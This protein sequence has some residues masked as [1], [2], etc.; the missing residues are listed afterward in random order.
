MRAIRWSP[1]RATGPARFSDALA[2]EAIERG[3]ASG[4][5]CAVIEEPAGAEVYPR[6]EACEVALADPL[7]PPLTTARID[8]GQEGGIVLGGSA[9]VDRCGV[10]GGLYGGASGAAHAPSAPQIQARTAPPMAQQR[11]PPRSAS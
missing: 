5:P 9:A 11:L 6:L 1:Q 4:A 2:I 8:A 7:D 3:M 10:A